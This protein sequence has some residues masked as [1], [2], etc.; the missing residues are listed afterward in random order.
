[1]ED[2]NINADLSKRD[3]EFHSMSLNDDMWKVVL[4]VGIPLALYQ[5][6]SAMF[7][8]L[9]TMMAS[10]IS[11]ESVSAVAY[12]NQINLL[13][14]AVGGGLAVG[15]GIQIANA[16]GK[17][18]FVLVKKRVSSLYAICLSI[19][20]LMLAG[21]LPFTHQFLVFVGTPE[22]LI[23]IG[24]QYFVV[25]MFTMVITFLNNVYITVERSRGNSKLIFRLNMVVII[26][27][28]TLTA[29]FVYV[30]NGNLVL[31]A[32]AS[33]ISQ[34]FLLI[35]GIINSQNGNSA[36]G[37]SL[38]AVS[39][40]KEVVEPMIHSSI[41]VIIE[42][43][44]FAFGKTIVNSMS[45][46]YGNLM[47]GAMGVSNNLGAITTN[48]QNGFQ[49]GSASIISQN[50]GAG[51]YKRVL[52]AFKWTLI[53]NVI[54][55][56]VISSIEL[57]QLD[58]L[59]SLFDSGNMELGELIKIT[60]TYEALGAIPLGINAA[61]MSLMYGLGKTK[62]TMV[63]HVSRVFVFRIPVFWFLQNYTNL[64]LKVPGMVMMISNTAVCVFSIIIAIFVIHDF[65]KEYAI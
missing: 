24:T 60:Y 2:K 47:V 39:K 63:I 4:Y 12:L 56:F 13:L 7:S 33:L 59:A 18:D 62:L 55:G 46:V 43:A 29:F 41:P 38:N 40:E 52:E 42:K 57:W 1:M 65:K 14:S 5:F 31:I 21:I 3:K 45:I 44:L 36:F 49:D 64:G 27:K 20:V 35:V 22:G 48:P 28:L 8:V 10:H 15:S 9:D 50:Y 25:S 54:I 53:F 30:V 23:E 58:F 34:L 17:G 26:L 11:R 19:G 6:I 61:I 37:F 32:V 16:F 51:K